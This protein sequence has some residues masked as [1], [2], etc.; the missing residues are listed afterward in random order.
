[1]GCSTAISASL[2]RG[3]AGGGSSAGL[4]P[5]RIEVTRGNSPKVLSILATVIK[6][7]F[8]EAARLTEQ[9]QY[10]V[11]STLRRARYN[12]I[13]TAET[14]ICSVL[15]TVKRNRED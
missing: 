4:R 8:A 12:S 11:A 15:L 9:L 10:I 3:R 14:T 5:L 1:M 2:S 6:A 13:A 7:L